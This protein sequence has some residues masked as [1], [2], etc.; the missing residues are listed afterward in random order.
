MVSVE[1]IDKIITDIINNFS[2]KCGHTIGEMHEILNGMSYDDQ[3][4][5]LKE[6]GYLNPLEEKHILNC[7]EDLSF[8]KKRHEQ[9]AGMDELTDTIRLEEIERLENELFQYG[10]RLIEGYETEFPVNLE[11]YRD[12]AGQPDEQ[13]DFFEEEDYSLLNE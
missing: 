7:I 8:N 6:K 2:T 13:F 5:Q 10:R 12:K 4:A 11:D 9:F 1:Q 3:F